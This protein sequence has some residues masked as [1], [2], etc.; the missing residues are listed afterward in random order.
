MSTDDRAARCVGM[1]DLFDSTDLA[2]HERAKAICAD[3][4]IAEAC[5]ATRTPGA[6]GTWGG[7]LFGYTGPRKK[8]RDGGR[9]RRI[10]AEARRAAEDAAYDDDE[11]RRAHNA[12]CAGDA[13]DWA[14]AGHRVYS[15]RKT[16]LGRKAA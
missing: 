3:C 8:D 2:D 13:S 16:A 12:Y 10:E 14:M 4:P 7:R 9:Q 11:A 1:H 15:R 5:R 6:H